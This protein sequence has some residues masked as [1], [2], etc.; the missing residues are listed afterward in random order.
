MSEQNYI[1]D[2]RK[3][4]GHDP[5][6]TVGCGVLIE[7]EKRELLL[8]KRSD[9]GQWCVPGGAM[10]LGETYEDAAKREVFEEVGIEV[11]DLELFGLYSGEER[12]IHYPNQDVVYSLSVIFHT[13]R[14]KGEIRNDD[15]EVI[16]HRFFAKDNLPE[17]LFLPDKR[18]ILHWAEE[19]KPVIVE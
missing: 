1:M 4:I 16:E 12:M 14:Y 9:N 3:T 17:E 10:E 19:R 13:R 8:Q 6:M 5:I 15:G 18:P 2:L 7:N 11:E